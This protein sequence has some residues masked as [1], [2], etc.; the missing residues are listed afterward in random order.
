M[1]KK[2]LMIAT[3]T[4]VLGLG[5]A[6]MAQ[7]ATHPHHHHTRRSET[8]LHAQQALQSQGLYEGRI[9][10]R[11]GP[12]THQ[13]VMQFQSQHGLRQTGRLDRETL[14]ALGSTGGT[15]AAPS[16]NAARSSSAG[17]LSASPLKPNTDKPRSNPGPTQPAP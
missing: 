9:D 12:R 3:S 13:A 8:V 7:T 11:D 17:T 4:L 2:M 5:T 6:A 16:N 14:A 1:L 15:G 10:G